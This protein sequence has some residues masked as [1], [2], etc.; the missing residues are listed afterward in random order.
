MPAAAI[1]RPNSSDV[2]GEDIDLGTLAAEGVAVA[3]RLVAASGCRV[4]FADDL[5]ASTGAADA[6]LRR[7]LD[8]ID[9]HVASRRLDT[10]VLD[11]APYRPVNLPP[12]LRTLNLATE[13]IANVIWAT[14]Y[15]SAYPWLQVPVLNAFGQLRQRERPNPGCPAS[16]ASDCALGSAATPASSTACA[17]TRGRSSPTSPAGPPSGTRIPAR[18]GTPALGPAAHSGPDDDR[19]SSARL[20]ECERQHCRWLRPGAAGARPR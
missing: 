10:E 12:A 4:T 15:R 5:A 13:K 11:P 6:A 8:N 1:C 17:T 7:L 20:R 16:T 18:C 9:S 2:P 3:G 19:R 14:G